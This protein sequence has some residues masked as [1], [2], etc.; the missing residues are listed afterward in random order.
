MLLWKFTLHFLC[1]AIIAFSLTHTS[2]GSMDSGVGV[3][4][5]ELVGKAISELL[6]AVKK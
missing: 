4:I 5:D 3:W 6:T 1:N 2:P